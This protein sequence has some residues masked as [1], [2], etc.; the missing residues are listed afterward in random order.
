M[1][2]ELIQKLSTDTMKTTINSDFTLLT[3]E[4]YLR[5][6]TENEELTIQDNI[7]LSLLFPQ[8]IKSLYPKDKLRYGHQINIHS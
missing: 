5:N 2:G 3:L 8:S 7:K 1:I 4:R 6:N